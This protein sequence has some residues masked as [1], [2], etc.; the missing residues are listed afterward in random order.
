MG[1]NHTNDPCVALWDT[2]SERRQCRRESRILTAQVQAIAA[3]RAAQA[4]AKA[5]RV[6]ARRAEAEQAKAVRVAARKAAQAEA[7]AARVAARKEAYAANTPG[8][9]IVWQNTA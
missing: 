9:D 6:A 5:V 4:E 8:V 7:T 1:G 2:P 3:R